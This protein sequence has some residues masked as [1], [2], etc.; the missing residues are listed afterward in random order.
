MDHEHS[1]RNRRR[2]HEARQETAEKVVAKV[3]RDPFAEDLL[4]MQREDPLD[5]HEDRRE[6]DEPDAELRCSV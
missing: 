5:R 4:A 2:E 3:D 1:R 6:D